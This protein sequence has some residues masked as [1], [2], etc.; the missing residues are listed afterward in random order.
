[1]RVPIGFLPMLVGGLLLLS[2]CESDVKLDEPVAGGGIGGTGKGTV[3]GFASGSIVVDDHRRFTIAPDSRI[4][5]DDAPSTA[6]ALEEVGPGLVARLVVAPDVGADFSSGTVLTLDVDQLVIGPVTQTELTLEVLGQK[7]ST[8]EATVLEGIG[9][10]GDLAA[11]DVV[12]VNGYA[13]GLHAIAATRVERL[14]AGAPVWKLTG[15]VSSLTPGTSLAIGPQ[16]VD[17]VG[18]TPA[19]CGAGLGVG[20]TVEL[21]AA[22]N[23][24]FTAGATLAN[25]RS[26]ACISDALQL[27]AA[28]GS[29]QIVAE[30]E[31]FVLSA[32][33]PDFELNDQR[34]T[35]TSQTAYIDGG[36]GD[37]TPGSQLLV[38][39]TLNTGTGI[40]TAGS[41]RFRKPRVQ[42]EAPVPTGDI[43]PGQS[44]RILGLT[45]YTTVHTVDTSGIVSAGNGNVQVSVHA[46]I[47]A[48]GLLYATTIRQTGAMDYNDVKLK[49]PVS[50]LPGQPHLTVFGIDADTTGAEFRNADHVVITE[51]EF[52]AALAIGRKV[53]LTG[54]T[55]DDALNAITSVA[56]ITLSN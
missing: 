29:S 8:D 21:Y 25:V 9:A 41:M 52:F 55:Y 37:I 56:T 48:G 27:P 17:I 39:G 3:T 45:V 22:A 47:G 16:P 42:M 2:A 7:V 43:V 50:G 19:Q 13:D 33:L 34:V 31:G 26:L 38:D 24:G 30:M 44:L 20:N 53:K 5:L 28:A 36:Y 1:M 23:P 15:D 10:I 12:A 14:A 11:G 49:G 40:L 4:T 6:A 18:V 46:Y 35:V 32:A 54:G 51:E